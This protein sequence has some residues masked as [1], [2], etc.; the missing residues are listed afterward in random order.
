M[1]VVAVG[2]YE[3]SSLCMDCTNSSTLWRSLSLV[4]GD[5]RRVEEGEGR[6]GCC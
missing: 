5:G 4:V 2:L 1:I 6:F 3:P